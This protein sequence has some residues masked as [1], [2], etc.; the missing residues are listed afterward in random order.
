MSHHWNHVAKYKEWAWKHW[1]TS[2]YSYE[3]WYIGIEKTSYSLY[4]KYIVTKK[5]IL[6]QLITYFES[7]WNFLLPCIFIFIL[8]SWRPLF[9]PW[10]TYFLPFIYCKIF[11][12]QLTYSAIDKCQTL[13][14]FFFFRNIVTVKRNFW[15]RHFRFW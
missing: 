7:V 15:K 4:F 14:S 2:Y 10:F 12:S 6:L 5:N 8:K 9:L 11:W 1:P 13:L 3:Y